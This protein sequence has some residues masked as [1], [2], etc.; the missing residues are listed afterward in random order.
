MKFLI[1]PIKMIYAFIV[2]IIFTIY[3]I[4][5]YG[6]PSI[7]ACFILAEIIDLLKS[8]LGEIKE[9]IQRKLKIKN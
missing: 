6:I 1:F 7:I 3:Y 5:V 8:I 2:I 4:L 9:K